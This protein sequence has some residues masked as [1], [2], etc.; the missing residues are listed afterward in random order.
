MSKA[1]ELIDFAK[2]NG[3]FIHG[4]TSPQEWEQ[5]LAENDGRCPCGHAES[6]PCGLAL[7]KINGPATEAA[8]QMCGCVF[9]VSKA[10][11]DHYK[12]KAWSE[13]TQSTNATVSAKKTEPK[14]GESVAYQKT[15][16]VSPEVEERFLKSAGTYIDALKLVES[17]DIDKFVD[18]IRMEE[19][20]N[21]CDI[22]KNDADVVASHGDYVRALCKNGSPECESEVKKLVTRTMEVIDENFMSAGYDKVKQTNTVASETKK[23]GKKNAWIEFSSQIMTDPSL[24]G[25]PQKNKMKIAAALYRGEYSSIEDA[26]EALGNAQNT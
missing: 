22:C 5:L 20:T 7:E 10:Y 24:D 17:G 6:C 16:E 23:T 25:L 4:R 12:S 21:P 26:R 3:I 8:D 18:N 11:L 9:Y 19:A 15:R 13:D 1:Q 14:Q 2:N